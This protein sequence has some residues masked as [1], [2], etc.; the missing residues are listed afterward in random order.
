M[1]ASM[2]DKP[3]APV[4]RSP[5]VPLAL[6]AL[7]LTALLASQTWSL[8]VERA[9]LATAQENQQPQ[10][11]QATKMRA[12]LDKLVATTRSFANEGSPAAQAVVNELAKRGVTINP[13]AAASAPK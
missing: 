12:A 4:G 8:A 2:T 1:S 7:T 6:L 10:V 9:T 11:E 3:E 13:A 5:F